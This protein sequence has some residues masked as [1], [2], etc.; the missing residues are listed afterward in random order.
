MSYQDRKD[1]DR[2]YQMIWDSD[3]NQLKLAGKEELDY[4]ASDIVNTIENLQVMTVNV[5]FN[6]SNNADGIR[7]NYVT[8]QLNKN[9]GFFESITFDE[10]NNFSYST[11]AMITDEYTVTVSS[12]EDYT[13]S[14]TYNN[15]TI[16][17]T[18]THIQ[19][20]IT[21][22]IYFDCDDTTLESFEVP[23][24][25]NGLEYLVEDMDIDG[26]AFEDVPKYYNP[27]GLDGD[28]RKNS[29]SLGVAST[30][31]YNIGCT[32]NADVGFTIIIRKKT[33]T[34][35]IKSN[36]LFEPSTTADL[37]HMVFDI[38]R[39]NTVIDDL[40]YSDMDSNHEYSTTVTVGS[41]TVVCH[42][43]YVRG[44]ELF[45]DSV[46]S[47]TLD[48]EEDQTSTFNMLTWYVESD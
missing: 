2:L 37:S 15:N 1:I 42:P 38:K 19:D 22:P 26:G 35:K 34:L 20:A 3:E 23:L 13:T 9:G 46:L 40:E 27:T 10:G 11:V 48:V 44:Y 28:E 39:G 36:V 41:Y 45:P 30:S 6:D 5:V 47:V 29:Y 7:P 32:G 17:I 14:I 12:I 24:L 8:A 16:T 43:V 4:L 33:G 21:I 31:E 25:Q 18:C